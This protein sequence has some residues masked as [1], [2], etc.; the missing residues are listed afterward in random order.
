MVD[1]DAWFPANSEPV[2]DVNTKQTSGLGLIQ[3]AVHTI[4]KYTFVGAILVICYSFV[5]TGL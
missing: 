2:K 5:F 3:Y 4:I 1:T